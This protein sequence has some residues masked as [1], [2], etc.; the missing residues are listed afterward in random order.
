MAQHLELVGRQGPV[1]DL[2]TDHLVV[3]ALTLTVDAVVQA[4]DAESVLIQVAGQVE[5]HHLLELVDVAEGGGIDLS[6]QHPSIVPKT[7]PIY[8]LSS[9]RSSV[10]SRPRR[11]PAR[12]GSIR[13]GTRQRCSGP[14]Q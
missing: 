14:E 1:G 11:F 13:P 4:E 9:R 12:S 2:D 6:R 8:Q 7:D 3:A 5:G 10:T